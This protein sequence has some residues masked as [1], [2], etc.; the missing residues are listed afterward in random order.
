MADPKD[1]VRAQFGRS[2]A[3]YASSDVHA[4]GDSLGLL[5]DL[6]RPEPHWTA[7]DVATGAGHTAL[8]SLS[9]T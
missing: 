5:V 3:A 4:R 9:R 1:L 7:L 6:V 2:A 8:A